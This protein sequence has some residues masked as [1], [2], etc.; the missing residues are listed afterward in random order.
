MSLLGFGTETVSSI[1]GARLCESHGAAVENW[2]VVRR[3]LCLIC[4][5]GSAGAG[6]K[7]STV[8]RSRFVCLCAHQATHT[9]E[10]SIKKRTH[11]N[12]SYRLSICIMSFRR[13]EGEE[14]LESEV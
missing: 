3:R 9:Q 8:V 2:T 12:G 4:V 13:T 14:I 10:R 7:I 5:C 6:V 11:E 1:L